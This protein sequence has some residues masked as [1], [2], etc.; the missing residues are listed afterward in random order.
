M[1]AEGAVGIIGGSGVYGLQGLE[2]VEEINVSTPFGA[3]SDS[4]IV[5]NLAGRKIVFLPRP[6]KEFNFN[7]FMPLIF[8]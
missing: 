3:P 1:A 2:G 7:I 4:Y 5:G 8:I 6:P